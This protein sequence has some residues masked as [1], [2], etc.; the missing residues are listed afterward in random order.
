MTRPL[1]LEY[2]GAVYEVM[3]R[4]NE[5]KPIFL[6]DHDRKEF[7]SALHLMQSRYQA[8]IHVYVLMA[9]HYHLLIET[10]QPNLSRIMHDLNSQYTIYFNHRYQRTGH[11]FQGRYKSYII[12]KENFLLDMSRYIHL[13]PV[14]SG[15]TQKP[16][17]YPY[18]SLPDYFADNGQHAWL[19]KGSVLEQL[20]KKGEGCS[21]Y[22]EYISH[23]VEIGDYAQPTIYANAIIGSRDFV[24]EIKEKIRNAGKLSKDIAQ[25]RQLR[26]GNDLQQIAESVTEYYQQTID[27][28]S[29]PKIKKNFAKK[30]FVYLS[31]K[32]TDKSLNEIK[33]FL[34][35]SITEVAISKLSRRTED[36][37]C[38]NPSLNED[39]KH[40]EKNLLDR[41]KL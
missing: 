5:D 4:G 1:R 40:I 28:L 39:K 32:Y 21:S 30:L 16:Q 41:R 26:N 34:N 33:E 31:R 22:R 7:L 12:D 9:N 13:N 35:D 8:I 36:E 25:A 23:C 14:R 10:P 2:E 11:L 18:S 15:I 17:D 19:V 3:S 37:L 6:D 29:R 27:I 20:Q 24:E 38:L